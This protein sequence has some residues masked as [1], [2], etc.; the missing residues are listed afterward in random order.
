MMQ[1]IETSAPGIQGILSIMA[2]PA[3]GYPRGSSESA[4]WI[5]AAGG[6]PGLELCLSEALL[7]EAR[8]C[9]GMRKLIMCVTR[10]LP[11]PLLV[12]AAA[13]ASSS[14]AGSISA[15]AADSA[16]ATGIVSGN[17]VLQVRAAS[18]GFLAHRWIQLGM[19]SDAVT[20]SYGPANLPFLDAGQIVVRDGS[21]HVERVSRWHLLP[22]S[23]TGSP[24]PG[25]GHAI[26]SAILISAAQA[27]RLL[28]REQ[29]HRFVAPYI[30]F[31]HDC[32][33]FVCAALATAKGQSTLPCYLFFKGHW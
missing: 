1:S 21:G 30:P 11:I 24:L 3:Q 5:A 29:R 7:F 16:P 26:G 22:G 13:A 14:P 8:E 19:S 2:T 17:V 33:T 4:A 18:G 31:F 32:H 20:I 15:P 27:R 25:A 6:L 9:N 12:I 23:F 10:L 28:R